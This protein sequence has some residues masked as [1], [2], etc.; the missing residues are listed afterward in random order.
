M[1]RSSAKFLCASISRSTAERDSKRGN[2]AENDLFK[3]LP[4]TL[5]KFAVV[6]GIERED[7]GA[8]DGL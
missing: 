8:K 1:D 5:A 2:L 3:A 4:D 6:A 7:V